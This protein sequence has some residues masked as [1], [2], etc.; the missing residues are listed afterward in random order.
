MDQQ[1]MCTFFNW[2]QNTLRDFNI[3]DCDESKHYYLKET[4]IG[5]WAGDARA[6]F[7]DQNDKM[8]TALRMMDIDKGRA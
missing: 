5:G 2:C 4:R 7:F 6:Y 1:E 3:K 8:A